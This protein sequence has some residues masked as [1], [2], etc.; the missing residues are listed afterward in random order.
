[1]GRINFGIHQESL[2]SGSHVVDEEIHRRKRL[3]RVGLEQ[4]DGKTGFKSGSRL[5]LGSH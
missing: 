2:P 4:G 1:M 3:A 5:Y